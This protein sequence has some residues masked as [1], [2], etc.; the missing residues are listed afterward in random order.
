MSSGKQI[1]PSGSQLQSRYVEQWLNDV[2]LD[3]IDL[4]LPG[5]LTRP[6]NLVPL[7]R[8]EIDRLKLNTLG[9]STET[10]DRIY[11]SLFVH[12]VGFF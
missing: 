10:T 2:I 5:V 4:K 1:G 6:E 11:R 8:Y 9:I 12:S 3:S 7:N